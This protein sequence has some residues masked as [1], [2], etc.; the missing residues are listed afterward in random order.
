MQAINKNPNRHNDAIALL[1]KLSEAREDQRA[2]S[3]F[4]EMVRRGRER[5]AII[6]ITEK[7]ESDGKN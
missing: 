4:S 2:R 1:P 5:G 6:S 3:A 7:S